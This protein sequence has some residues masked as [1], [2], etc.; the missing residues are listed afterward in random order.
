MLS[1]QTTKGG[2]VQDKELIGKVINGWAKSGKAYYDTSEARPKDD[3]QREIFEYIDDFIADGAPTG[4]ATS[5]SL[6]EIQ[7]SLEKTMPRDQG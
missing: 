4:L 6:E 2:R 3:A 1:E 7:A 5:K